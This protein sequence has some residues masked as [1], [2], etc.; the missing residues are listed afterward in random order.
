MVEKSYDSFQVGDMALFS[1]TITESNIS[2][3]AGITGDLNP[4]K[5]VILLEG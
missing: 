4:V 3:Y 2:N 5:F 1:K